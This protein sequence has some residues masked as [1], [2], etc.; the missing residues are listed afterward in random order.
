MHHRNTLGLA[1]ALG[2]LLLVT[3]S[4]SSSDTPAALG[5]VGGAIL[6]EADDHCLG[7]PQRVTPE[8]CTV[9]AADDAG[10]GSHPDGVGGGAGEGGAASH[11]EGGGHSDCN[12]THDVAYGPTL[13]NSS[14]WDD[15]CKYDVSWTSTPI[16]KDQ[17][18]TFTIEAKSLTTDHG[19]EPLVAG[20][21]PLSRVDVYQPCQP[22]RRGPIQNSK[23]TIRESATG[24]YTAGPLRFDQAG[25]WVVRFHFY[26]QCLDSDAS[27]HA[28][29]AFFLD[30][31]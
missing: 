31:P 22:T 23:A 20:Q 4:C 17:D 29:V 26:E 24:T 30:V 5:P 1:L 21:L 9:P 11:E 14:G 2:G 18:V 27:P 3:P 28:H 25:R 6:A 15:D 10:S 13:S 8:S 16:R 19:L 12:E 7:V